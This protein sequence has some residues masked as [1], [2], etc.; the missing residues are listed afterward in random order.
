VTFEFP[1]DLRVGEFSSDDMPGWDSPAAELT[2]DRGD[3][4]LQDSRGAV[5]LVPSIVF[6]VERNALLNPAHADFGA[7]RVVEVAPVRWDDRLFPRTS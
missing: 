5:L 7:V 6:D 2:R 3:D 4:W 1:D